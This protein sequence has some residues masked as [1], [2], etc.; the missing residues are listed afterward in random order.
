L[1][2]NLQNKLPILLLILLI[3]YF[4]GFRAFSLIH[5][6]SHSNNDSNSHHPSGIESEKHNIS[7]KK[8]SQKPEDKNEC[9]ICYLFHFYQN[10]ILLFAG[11]FLSLILLCFSN[12]LAP[13]H[14][15]RTSSPSFFYQTRAPPIFVKI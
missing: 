12:Y 2:T 7:D 13:P 8:N 3:A 9:L 10:N 14:K 6:I 15:I 1:Q 11:L 4:I 5:Q